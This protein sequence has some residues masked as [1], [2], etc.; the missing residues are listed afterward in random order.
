MR[1][2]GKP[3]AAELPAEIRPFPRRADEARAE[4]VADGLWRL[5]L[6]VPYSASGTVNCY[7]IDRADGWCLVDCGTSIEP[8][9]DALEHALALAG[10]EPRAITLLLCTHAHPDH[11]GLAAAVVER[12]GCELALAPGPLAVADLLRDPAVPLQR[13]RLLAARAGV[14]PAIA[15]VAV[16]PPGDDC[17]HPRPEPDRPLGED[18]TIESRAGR[19]RV[20]PAPGHAPTQVVLLNE[21]RRLLVS[22]DLALAGRIPYLEYNYTPDPWAEQVESVARARALRPELLLP[23]H[24]EPVVDADAPLAAAAGAAEAAPRRI[25]GSIAREARSA[26][27]VVLDVLGEDSSFYARHTALAGALCVLERLERLGEAVAEVHSDG[28]VRFRATTNQTVV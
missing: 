25:L 22:A 28:A 3:P 19:W 1:R 7:L 24:G 15:G 10:V 26:Y 8:G 5:R 23:G 2:A 11:F 13:R 6:P 27:E 9:W 21:P 4:A 20:V 16:R 18:D 12:A 17:R 14:P